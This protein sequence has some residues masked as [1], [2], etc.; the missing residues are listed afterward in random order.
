MK[1]V[2]VISA[3]PGWDL[4]NDT[5]SGRRDVSVKAEAPH[6]RHRRPDHLDGRSSQHI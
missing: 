2:I 3:S 5:M 6:D 1:Q 4:S